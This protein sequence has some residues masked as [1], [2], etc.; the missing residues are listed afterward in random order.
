[1]GAFTQLRRRAAS[2]LVAHWHLADPAITKGLNDKFYEKRKAAA[3][4]LEKCVE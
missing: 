2:A 4:D 1:M 3:L